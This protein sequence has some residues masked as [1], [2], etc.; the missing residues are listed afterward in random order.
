M[1]EKVSRNVLYCPDTHEYRVTSM[2]DQDGT[3]TSIYFSD[4]EADGCGC[5]IHDLLAMCT[6]HLENKES[7]CPS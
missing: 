1:I 4:D 6:H 2:P 5:T 3:S 7:C